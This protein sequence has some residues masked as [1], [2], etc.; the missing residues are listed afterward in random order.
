MV[1]SP[2]LEAAVEL[3]TEL[4]KF[5][6]SLKS[7]G[8]PTTLKTAADLDEIMS[9]ITNDIY[10]SLKL[11]EYYVIDVVSET[12]SFS[13]AWTNETPPAPTGL[14]VELS[15]LP[16]RELSA[17]F[18]KICLPENWS[19]LG[20]RF[21]TRIDPSKAVGF[22]AA[23][24][25]LTPGKSTL[26]EASMKLS[27]ILDIINVPQYEKYDADRET[28]LRN[29]KNRI[30]Y[31]RLDDHGPKFGP[32]TEK[33]IFSGLF[34]A[35]RPKLTIPLQTLVYHSLSLSS[36]GSPHHFAPKSTTLAL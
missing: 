8:L 21:K 10:P 22:I 20:P 6:A 1:N 23:L 7:R 13:T 31:T 30:K 9:V 25:G 12:K 19:Y 24:T 26:D 34:C 16:D 5:S 33:F 2:H 28:A 32:V 35:H 29:T 3:D 11:Y 15:T 18:A 17:A 14:F 27:K 36:L 4:L